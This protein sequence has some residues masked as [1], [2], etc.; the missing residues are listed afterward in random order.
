MRRRTYT[1]FDEEAL[2]AADA[3]LDQGKQLTGVPGDDTAIEPDVDPALAAAR[4]QFLLKALDCRRRRDGV[5]R[6]IDDRGHA[7][8]RSGP[9]PC[10]EPLPLGPPRLVEVNMGIDETWKKELGGVIDVAGSGGEV[11]WWE[12]LG[13]DVDDLAGVWVDGDGGRS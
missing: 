10:P 8:A 4:L 2:E 7:A 5:E 6:H 12:D 11:G 1:R 9:R 13:Q 3:H